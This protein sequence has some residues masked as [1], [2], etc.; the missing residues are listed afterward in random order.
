MLLSK[1]L[2]L[3]NQAE[4]PATRSSARPRCDNPI[5]G[6]PTDPLHPPAPWDI[7]STLKLVGH[8]SCLIFWQVVSRPRYTLK[9]FM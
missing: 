2:F 3:A 1:A 5:T 4:L 6:C 9:A 7:F 8:S